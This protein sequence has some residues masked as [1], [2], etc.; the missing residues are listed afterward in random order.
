MPGQGNPFLDQIPLRASANVE[1]CRVIGLTSGG[2]YTGSKVTDKTVEPIGISVEFSF[3]PPIVDYSLS[4]VAARTGD[5]LAFYGNGT[6]ANAV[7][8]ATAITAQ[9]RV[10]AETGG[11]GKVIPLVAPGWSIGYVGDADAPTG[12]KVEVFVDIK[13]FGT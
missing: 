7:V 8:G 12:S 1:T 4:A 9:G 6:K 11:T 13:Y 10:M 5:P 2:T 3:L